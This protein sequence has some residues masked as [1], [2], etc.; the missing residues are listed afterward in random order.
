M[1]EDKHDRGQHPN[2]ERCEP[3]KEKR[4]CRKCER[5]Q[6]HKV[7]SKSEE[8]HSAEH[9]H[10]GQCSVE[11]IVRMPHDSVGCGA[12]AHRA[13]H[14]TYRLP[15]SGNINK[16]TC[17]REKNG[18]HDHGDIIEAYQDREVKQD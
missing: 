6:E 10:E 15:S 1:Q 5:N 13:G 4:G 16:D 9:E 2:L 17:G 12:G 7:F 3:V 14:L 8:K 11:N 18:R